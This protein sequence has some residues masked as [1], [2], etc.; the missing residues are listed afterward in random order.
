MT[1]S[2]PQN[3]N[4]GPW[5]FAGLLWLAAGALAVVTATDETFLRKAFL[6]FSF[7]AVA[8]LFCCWLYSLVLFLRS[9][10]FSL[11][12]FLK[13]NWLS[14]A[15]AFLL[16]VMVFLSVKPYFRVLSDETNLLAVSKSMLLRHSVENITQAKWD[17]FEFFPLEVHL[18]KRPFLF[19]FM[20]FLLHAAFGFS[21]AHVFIVNFIALWSLLAL[22][23]IVCRK[24]WGNAGAFSAALLVLAQP[25]VTQTAAS[26]SFDLFFAFFMLLSLAAFAAYVYRPSAAGF[27]FLWLQLLMLSHIRYEGPVYF[28]LLMAIFFLTGSMKN[29]HWKNPWIL[30][31][32][33]LLLLPVLWQRFFL[34]FDYEMRGGAEFFSVGNFF[35]HCGVFLKELFRFDFFMPYAGMINILGLVAVLYLFY[36]VIFQNRRLKDSRMAVVLAAGASVFA[37]HW[38]ILNSLGGDTLTDRDG[39]RLWTLSSI[40]FSL[41]AAWSLWRFTARINR[42]V[43]MLVTAAALFGLY[44]PVSI[45]NRFADS[46]NLP[47]EHRSVTAFLE[48]RPMDHALLIAYRP[49]VYAALNYAAVNF[50]YANYYKPQMLD[51]IREHYYR[52]IY[53]LQEIVTA[54]GQPTERTQLDPAYKLEKAY[55]VQDGFPSDVYLRISRVMN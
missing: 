6:S 38:I 5:I 29:Q 53:V 3:I 41:A 2:E 36:F 17:Q 32:T 14:L 37:V 55:E 20:V 46:M 25:V 30:G 11:H 12:G 21:P 51:E 10:D 45:E 35:R 47:R 40:V 31:I 22:I 44:H 4:P 43:M 42:P 9:V 49:G 24:Y 54:T 26:G 7:Y 33:P 34:E 1:R 18:P 27:A 52:D 8:A 23:L 28:L 48:T 50:K 15:S 13:Q 16:A 39:S 19:P